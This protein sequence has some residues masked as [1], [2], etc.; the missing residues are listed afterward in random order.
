M[1]ENSYN[2]RRNTED[3]IVYGDLGD[4]PNWAKAFGGLYNDL[5]Y[6][7][8]DVTAAGMDGVYL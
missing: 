8:Y 7:E 6:F 4:W 3:L 1:L 2:I 5:A